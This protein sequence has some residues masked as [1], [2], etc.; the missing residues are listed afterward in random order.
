MS[1]HCHQHEYQNNPY[2]N[3]FIDNQHEL[4]IKDYYNYNQDEMSPAQI[5]EPKVKTFPY[6]SDDDIRLSMSDRNTSEKN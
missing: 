6:L 5:R 1:K 4:M 3:E 2:S